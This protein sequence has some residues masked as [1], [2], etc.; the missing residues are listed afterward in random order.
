L[1]VQLA[2]EV[3]V[4]NGSGSFTLQDKGLS[5]PVGS[6]QGGVAGDFNGDGYVDIFVT[7]SGAI[8]ALYMKPGQ[9]LLQGRGLQPRRRYFS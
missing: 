1:T 7:R 4:N 3:Y 8:C 5:A 9:R 6:A 2:H